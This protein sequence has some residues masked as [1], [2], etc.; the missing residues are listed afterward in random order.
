MNGNILDSSGVI[1]LFLL[2]ISFILGTLYV[3][4]RMKN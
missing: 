3:R 4:E 1:I 2:F